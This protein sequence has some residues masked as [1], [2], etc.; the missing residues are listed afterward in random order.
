MDT[1]TYTE[2]AYIERLDDLPL[3][4]ALQQRLDLASVIDRHIRRHWLHQ[5]LSIGQLVVGWAAY[6]LSQADHRKVRVREW[7]AEHPDLL[8]EWLD[9]PIR[10]TD[11]TDDRL[12]QVLTHLSDDAAWAALEADLWQQTVQVYRLRPARVRLDPT[13]VHGYH[14]IRDEGL[15]QYGYSSDHPGQPQVKIVA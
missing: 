10:D 5:G 8:A 2:E 15:M 4:L 11:F 14:T 6:I 3:L 13:T 1:T 9:A 12:G 7:A